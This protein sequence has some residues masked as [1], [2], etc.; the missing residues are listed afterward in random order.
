MRA[1][2]GLITFT[3]IVKNCPSMG[4]FK[5]IP[6]YNGFVVRLPASIKRI[7]HKGKS[8]VVNV[9][10]SSLINSMHQIIYYVL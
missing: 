4:K 1:A 5:Q 7:F 2:Y 6:N 9:R 3:K 10:T 8:L